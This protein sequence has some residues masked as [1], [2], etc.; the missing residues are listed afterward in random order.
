MV[1]EILL[2]E[3]V[4]HVGIYVGDIDGDGKGDVMDNIGYIR[5]QS[6][7]EWIQW[8]V[9]YGNTAC[10]G[11]PGWLGWGWQ[12]GS[13]TKIISGGDEKDDAD[14]DDK[15]DDDEEVSTVDMQLITD[16]GKVTFY[17]GC[18]FYRVLYV[19]TVFGVFVCSVFLPQLIRII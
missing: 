18:F 8:Q 6:L 3:V 11:K 15:K 13:P 17:N 1:Q 10:G 14:D 16:N 7:E 2:M 19:F 4:G 5:T 12:S 9:N